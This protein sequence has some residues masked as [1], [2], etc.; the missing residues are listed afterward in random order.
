MNATRCSLEFDVILGCGLMTLPVRQ[1][2]PTFGAD[3]GHL[4][5]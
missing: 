1:I 4:E 3:V 5:A 2:R